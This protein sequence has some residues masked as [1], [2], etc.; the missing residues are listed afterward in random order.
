MKIVASTAAVL[1]QSD[2]FCWQTA[3]QVL[4][5]LCWISLFD[6]FEHKVMWAFQVLFE[7][8]WVFPLSVHVRKQQKEG[9]KHLL[10]MSHT[11]CFLIYDHYSISGG[12]TNKPLLYRIWTK[13]LPGHL[14]LQIFQVCID[15][16]SNDYTKWEYIIMLTNKTYL[17]KSMETQSVQYEINKIDTVKKK[18]I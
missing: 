3:F 6:I 17:K 1:K 7:I 4:S 18:I 15:N 12:W 2:T 11:H 5:A 8:A 16:E 9:T 13:L 10:Q 14:K